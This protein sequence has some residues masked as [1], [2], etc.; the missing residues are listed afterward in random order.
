[1][2][3]CTYVCT[4][5]H[6]M[7]IYTHLCVRISIYLFIY[8]YTYIYIISIDLLYCTQCIYV[9]RHGNVMK[10]VSAP[11][12]TCKYKFACMYVRMYVSMHVYA[13][14]H[15][16]ILR[17]GVYTY[18]SVR[19]SCVSCYILYGYCLHCVY[20]IVF[21][22]KNMVAKLFLKTSLSHGTQRIRSAGSVCRGRRPR[23]RPWNVSTLAGAVLLK[24]DPGFEVTQRAH[25]S[26][27]AHIKLEQRDAAI[28]K[29]GKNHATKS[30]STIG[31][32]NTKLSSLR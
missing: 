6:E 29:R 5:V 1:M 10:V 23:V 22:F 28:C 32:T 18:I 8:L 16:Y 13:D 20:V 4:Y 12:D 30:C 21:R 14:L 2:H 11:A 17:T 7:D 15:T 25:V 9:Y 3:A 24:M 31:P 26:G 19:V 27:L